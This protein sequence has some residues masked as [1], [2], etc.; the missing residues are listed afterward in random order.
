MLHKYIINICFL[1]KEAE[2]QFSL[3]CHL[4]VL[5]LLWDPEAEKLLSQTKT[6]SRWLGLLL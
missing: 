2:F 5:F 4:E 3:P 6:K 1:S